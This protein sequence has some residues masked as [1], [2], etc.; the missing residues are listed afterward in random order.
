[1]W[2]GRVR[3]AVSSMLS[4]SMPTERGAGLGE[5]LGGVRGQE[6]VALEILVGSPVRSQPVWTSTALPRTSSPSKASRVDG[7]AGRRVDADDERREVRELLQ[8]QFGE[9]LAVGEAVE[10][11]VEVGAGVGDH[12]DLA[13]V[14]LGAGGVDLPRRFARQ[15]VAH[16]RGGQPLVGHHP[17]F[18]DVAHVDQSSARLRRCIHINRAAAETPKAGFTDSSAGLSSDHGRA[19]DDFALALVA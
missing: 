12:L 5:E 7:P 1:M 6:R 17:A 15:E 9:V 8:R 18:D 10:R 14:E 11:R 2:T 3:S 4:E 19:V 13:D 16:E